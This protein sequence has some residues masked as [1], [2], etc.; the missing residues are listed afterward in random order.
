MA[1]TFQS[2]LDT[3]PDLTEE[4]RTA[5]IEQNEEILKTD[6]TDA[7]TLLTEGLKELKG[8]L[9][10]PVGVSALPDGKKYYEYLLN[11]STC[12]S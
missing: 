6:F 4:E 8:H 5:Y 9:A 2:R 12:T 11:S 10:L 1:E 7:Y 3:L